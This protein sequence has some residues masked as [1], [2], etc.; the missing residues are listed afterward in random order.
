MISRP[1]YLDL[2]G[3]WSGFIAD[4]DL[5]A[6]QGHDLGDSHRADRWD[7]CAVG[8]G[9]GLLGVVGSCRGCTLFRFHIASQAPT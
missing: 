5:A 7:G 4:E 3:H 6:L 9:A 8:D 2:C 1:K